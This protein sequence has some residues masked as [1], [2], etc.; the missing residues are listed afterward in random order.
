MARKF[1]DK[2]TMKPRDYTNYCVYLDGRY[3]HVPAKAYY[4]E[5]YE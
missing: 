4:H 5:S 1:T 2:E 3:Y